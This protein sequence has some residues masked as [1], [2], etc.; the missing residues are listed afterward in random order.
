MLCCC[1]R[2]YGLVPLVLLDSVGS[3]CCVVAAVTDS[4]VA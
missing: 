1:K 3:C 2:I 4:E